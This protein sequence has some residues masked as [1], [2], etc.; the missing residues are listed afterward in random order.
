VTSPARFSQW[1]PLAK[2][3]RAIK[4]VTNVLESW[5]Y[6]QST[7]NTLFSN[8]V[9]FEYIFYACCLLSP[10]MLQVYTSLP[11]TFCRKYQQPLVNSMVPD[12]LFFGELRRSCLEYCWSRTEPEGWL[13]AQVNSPIPLQT[14]SSVEKLRTITKYLWYYTWKQ[15][16]HIS[17]FPIQ[18]IYQYNCVIG[19]KLLHIHCIIH[20]M[21]VK[22]YVK[23]QIVCIPQKSNL[24]RSYCLHKLTIQP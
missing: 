3:C 21:M 2:Q 10:L 17:S 12:M 16:C 9:C 22:W 7:Q 23:P 6:T 15:C 13:N 1:I 5:A 4:Q 11:L 14:Q 19:S 20:S 8:W 24:P 18:K